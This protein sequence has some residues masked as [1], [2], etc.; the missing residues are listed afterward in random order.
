MIKAL[1]GLAISLSFFL[2][3]PAFAGNS[4]P[5]VCGTCVSDANY[6][7]SCYAGYGGPAYA[8]YGGPAYAGYGGACYAGYGGPCHGDAKECPA[9]CSCPK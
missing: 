8:G 2:C 5:A 7:G 3:A 6:G 1:L 4:C 9:V